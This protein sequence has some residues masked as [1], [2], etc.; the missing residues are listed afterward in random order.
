MGAPLKTV[1][2]LNSLQAPAEHLKAIGQKEEHQA[3]PVLMGWL[4]EGELL[5][6]GRKAL[7]FAGENFVPRACLDSC[8]LSSAR[9][10]LLP[11]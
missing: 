8:L 3:Q 6:F 2:H 9:L 1:F 7:D 11:A 5:W 10:K 4:N